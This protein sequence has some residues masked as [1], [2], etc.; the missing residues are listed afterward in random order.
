M[1]HYQQSGR[2]YLQ[3]RILMAKLDHCVMIDH[4]YEEDHMKGIKQPTWTVRVEPYLL[5]RN[6]YM[7]VATWA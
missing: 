2:T 1:Y 7:R 4:M 5:L 3:L 6:T